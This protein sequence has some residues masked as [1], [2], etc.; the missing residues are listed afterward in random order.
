MLIICGDLFYIESIKKRY[1]EELEDTK[2]IA[3]FGLPRFI[4]GNQMEN[5]DPWDRLTLAYYEN[6]KRR[7]LVSIHIMYDD[8]ISH[9]S[10]VSIDIFDK[11]VYAGN[12][13]RYSSLQS[14]MKFAHSRTAH[15]ISLEAC[16]LLN[17][18]KVSNNLQR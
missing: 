5:H 15:K 12:N 2:L 11:T 10:E 13:D 7:V 4:E 8:D 1:A 16:G 3:L 17:R 14:R 18:K 9:G 6:Y